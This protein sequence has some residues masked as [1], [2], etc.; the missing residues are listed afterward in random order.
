[1]DSP[2]DQMYH[3]LWLN[4]LIDDNMSNA[5]I[6]IFLSRFYTGNKFVLILDYHI[7]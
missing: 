6:Q 3:K 5:S 1:M 4:G 2:I 7:Q